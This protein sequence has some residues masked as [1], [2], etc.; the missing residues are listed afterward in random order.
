MPMSYVTM[1][2]MLFLMALGAVGEFMTGGNLIGAVRDAFPSDLARR[3]ALERC[4]QMDAQ[5][6]RFSQSDR[7]GCY[8]AML[9]ASAR[10]S[11]NAAGEW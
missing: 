1:W 5:F 10:V 11:S 4:G 9:P 2:G 6:S 3:E 8:R 7:D